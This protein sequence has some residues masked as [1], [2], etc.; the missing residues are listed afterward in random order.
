MIR[1]TTPTLTDN[2]AVS[3]VVG[4]I[5]IVA[6]TVILLGI[7]GVGLLVLGT[8]IISEFID[9]TPYL[10]PV[11]SLFILSHLA[12]FALKKRDQK[13]TTLED[14]IEFESATKEIRD[15]NI[16]ADE[17]KMLKTS[18]E[19]IHDTEV[20]DPLTVAPSNANPRNWSLPTQLDESKT[21]TFILNTEYIPSNFNSNET[22]FVPCKEYGKL[23]A[24]YDTGDFTSITVYDTELNEVATCEFEE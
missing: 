10:I 6:I 3:P 11:V 7:I 14:V 1:N 23:N 2:R 12:R 5:L 24:T 17:I 8:N 16:E 4:V 19:T 18:I 22:V 21:V 9:L 20:L 15:E 13:N